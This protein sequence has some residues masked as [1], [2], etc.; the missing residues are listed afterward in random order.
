[1]PVCWQLWF[2]QL[3]IPTAPLLLWSGH[4]WITRQASQTPWG[5]GP[6][7]W[8]AGH[9]EM[10]QPRPLDSPSWLLA[11]QLFLQFGDRPQLPLVCLLLCPPQPPW[12]WLLGLGGNPLPWPS[13]S[14][15]GC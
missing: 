4:L 15:A 14:L 5:R 13:L 11:G 8:D 3:G 10:L 7:S 1:M 12:A 9:S 2:C 6:S